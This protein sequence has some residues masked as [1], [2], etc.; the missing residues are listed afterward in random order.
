[1]GGGTAGLD[2][3]TCRRIAQCIT[4][5][6]SCFYVGKLWHGLSNRFFF[7]LLIYVNF[8]LEDLCGMGQLNVV[9]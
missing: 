7:E 3:W 2:N 9:F 5:S 6:A 1:M 8:L 4:H